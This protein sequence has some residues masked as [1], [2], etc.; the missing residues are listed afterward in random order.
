MYPITEVPM[1][2]TPCELCECV[3]YEFVPHTCDSEV[4]LFELRC[5]NCGRDREELYGIKVVC[6]KGSIDDQSLR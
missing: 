6:E 4:M 1:S 3:D 5:K 2:V